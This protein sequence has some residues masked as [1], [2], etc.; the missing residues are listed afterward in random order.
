MHKSL[1]WQQSTL[2]YKVLSKKSLFGYKLLIISTC[3]TASAYSINMTCHSTD[4]GSIG[5]QH[6]RLHTSPCYSNK[7]CQIIFYLLKKSL[8]QCKLFPI[9]IRVT[10]CAS[11][12]NI[13]CH[14]TVNGVPENS[15]QD[16]AQAIAMATKHSKLKLFVEEILIWMQTPPDFDPCNNLCMHNQHHT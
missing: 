12:I 3:G 6:S 15:N 7:T 13:T 9:S 8:F 4:N 2:N 10:T 5:K 16:C 1:L 14:S 11:T